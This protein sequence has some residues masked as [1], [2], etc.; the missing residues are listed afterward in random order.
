MEQIDNKTI[1][2]DVL[3][4][5]HGLINE[6]VVNFF[7][8][9]C[10]MTK[11]YAEKNHD[12]GNSFAKGVKELGNMYAISR[13]YDKLNRIINLDKRKEGAACLDESMQDTIRDLSCYSIMLSNVHNDIL[14]ATAD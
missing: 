4:I 13:L 5:E 2:E 14:R 12:Y 10:N 9:C 3:G 11:L 6:D 1:L 8:E 7:A